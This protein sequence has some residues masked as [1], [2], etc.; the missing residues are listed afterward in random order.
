MTSISETMPLEEL[1][2]PNV[3]LRGG[4][5]LVI[6]DGAE[7][8][9]Y[10]D[11]DGLIEELYSA[12]IDKPARLTPK[13]IAYLREAADMTQEQAARFAG[14]NMRTWRRYESAYR[15]TS[16]TLSDE[17]F[18]R[19][20]ILERLKRKSPTY[21]VMNRWKDAARTALSS[22]LLLSRRGD[23]WISSFVEL[24]KREVILEIGP[25]IT[26]TWSEQQESVTVPTNSEGK[27]REEIRLPTLSETREFDGVTT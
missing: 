14:V 19:A 8:I 5:R 21:T 11:F 10:E 6:E 24:G 20:K 12:L 16:W 2:L 17:A 13:E 27:Q 4:F 15:P 23:K 7:Y 22:A 1:G 26:T 9:E 18:F 3:F 25:M